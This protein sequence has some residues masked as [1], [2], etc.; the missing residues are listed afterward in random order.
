M[1]DN[2]KINSV[3]KIYDKMANDYSKYWDDDW[4]DKEIID[5]FISML[6]SNSK[7]L[8]IGCGTGYVT[9]YLKESGLAPIGIDISSEMLRIAKLK[10]PQIDFRELSASDITKEFSENEFDGVMAF[11]VLFYIPKRE[12][13]E[14]IIKIRSILKPNA[15]LILVMKEGNGETFVKDQFSNSDEKV[16]FC[17]LYTE[18]EMYNFLD[19]NSFKLESFIVKENYNFQEITKGRTF[20][21]IVRNIK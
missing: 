3:K 18:S 4:S 17:N 10:Y 21:F 9:N 2:D 12:L 13:D 11:Y 6:N 14:V 15:P 5:K 19:K 20:I 16:L 7:V 8:D 1:K